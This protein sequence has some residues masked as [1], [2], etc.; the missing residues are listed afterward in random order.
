MTLMCFCF[1]FT[2]Y[3]VL[4]YLIGLAFCH[5]G[6]MQGTIHRLLLEEKQSEFKAGSVLLLKQVLEN[7]KSRAG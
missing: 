2:V 3:L 7:K 1:D 4:L 5:A 6:E